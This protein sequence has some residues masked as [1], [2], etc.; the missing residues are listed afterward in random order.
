MD[1]IWSAVHSQLVLVYLGDIMK[2]P[3]SPE[4]HI[5]HVR[6]VLTLICDAVVT[7]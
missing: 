3:K 1:V 5:N 7:I 4:A 2:F 6:H